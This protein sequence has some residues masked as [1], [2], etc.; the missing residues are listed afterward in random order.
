MPWHTLFSALALNEIKGLD[1]TWANN[2][3]TYDGHVIA[4]CDVA[5]L[6]APT[7]ATANEIISTFKD[8]FDGNFGEGDVPKF[9]SFEW[10]CIYGWLVR[11]S[12]AIKAKKHETNGEDIEKILIYTI[13]LQKIIQDKLSDN[14]LIDAS[15][16]AKKENRFIFISGNGDDPFKLTVHKQNAAFF[17]D[18]RG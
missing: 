14:E 8:V 9:N 17:E 16:M 12:E 4:E 5:P 2:K 13:S 11:F 18:K 10:M 1:I 7:N 6:Y 15:E 3:F